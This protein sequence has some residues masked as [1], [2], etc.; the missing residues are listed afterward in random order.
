MRRVKSVWSWLAVLAWNI[1]IIAL[2]LEVSGNLLYWWDHGRLLLLRE[3]PAKQTAL[4]L[5]PFSDGDYRPVLHP[6]FGYVYTE[7]PGGRRPFHLN[8]H[9]FVQ[10]KG[11]V[12]RHPGCCD[13]PVLD[14]G[15]DEI[16]VGIF[17]GSVASAVAI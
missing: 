9:D 6:Y 11:Y 17:G 16:I 13:F 5:E 7:N 8:N 14:R 1:L 4:P 2:L 15:P 10:D 3:E 12:E